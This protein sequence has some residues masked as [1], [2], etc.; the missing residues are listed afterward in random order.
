M[1]DH[2]AAQKH[3][4]VSHTLTHEWT[5]KISNSQPEQS[6]G[7]WCIAT[8]SVYSTVAHLDYSKMPL[9]DTDMHSNPI[10]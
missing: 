8:Y 10:M 7:I 3:I 6:A 1:V 2:W 9:G 4:H 5:L